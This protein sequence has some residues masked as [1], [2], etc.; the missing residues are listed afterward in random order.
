MLSIRKIKTNEVVVSRIPLET[1]DPKDT[2]DDIIAPNLHHPEG[3]KHSKFLKDLSEHDI[4]LS[5]RS[6]NEN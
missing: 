5:L 4:Y 2:V 3:T 6:L 1:I